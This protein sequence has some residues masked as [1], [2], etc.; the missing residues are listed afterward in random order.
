MSVEARE[1]TED[2]FSDDDQDFDELVGSLEES[3]AP[4]HDELSEGQKARMEKNKL[5]ALALKKSRLLAHPYSKT[6]NTAS[7]ASIVKEKKLVD[8]GGGFFIEEEDEVTAEE[9]VITEMPPP[10]MPPDQPTCEE[11][12][13]DFADSYLYNTFDHSVCDDCK[14]MER[15][16]PHELITKTEA[17]KEFILKD[18]DF[19]KGERG[20]TLRFLLRKNPHNPRYG[21][22][23]LYLRLQ[24]EKRALGMWGSE[25]AL[26]KEHEQREDNRMALKTKKYNKKMKELRKAV[27]SSLFTKDF[28]THKHSYGEE[29]YD[30]EK[31]EY[32][33]VCDGCGH[34]NIYEKM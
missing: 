10:I 5:K 32:S 22:M 6:G 1:D 3:E 23:K 24:V 13:K 26:E 19:E 15:E 21:D 17:K 28:S 7:K 12:D 25:D 9:A 14:D 4:D 16:G 30:E 11:C 31:D 18:S 8:G 29:T 34:V 20:H 33:K 27:R 2:P